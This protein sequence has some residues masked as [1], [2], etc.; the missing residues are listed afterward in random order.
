MENVHR[1]VYISMSRRSL[2]GD[3]EQPILKRIE[4]VLSKFVTLPFGHHIHP[5]TPP[6]LCIDDPI[7][8]HVEQSSTLSIRH[9]DREEFVEKSFCNLSLK[10]IQMQ[11]SMTLNEIDF[12]VYLKCFI[13]ELRTPISTISLGL[14]LLKEGESDSER[15]QTIKDISRS[16]TFIEQI[17][18]KFANIQEGNIVLNAFEP[19]SMKKLIATVEILIMYH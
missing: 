6:T 5:F 13:H 14:N 8:S 15:Q 9:M 18:T 4:K 7:Q 17:L 19:F 3:N 12:N 2:N 16:V 10:K 11:P 1:G